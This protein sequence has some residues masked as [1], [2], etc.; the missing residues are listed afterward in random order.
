MVVVWVARMDAY[1]V[2]RMVQQKGETM[3]VYLAASLDVSKVE[4]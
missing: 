3:A 2:G 4:S 1:L